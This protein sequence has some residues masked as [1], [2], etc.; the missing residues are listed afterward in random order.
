MII[1]NS[2]RKL[3]A[4]GVL[5]L[6]VSTLI[7]LPLYS[8]QSI[9]RCGTT[10]YM[11]NLKANDPKLEQKLIESEQIIQQWIRDN[12]DWKSRRAGTEFVIPVVVH[13]VY[14]TTAQN[15]TDQQVFSQIDVLNEDFARLNPDTNL[16][17]APFAA[18]A[19]S[20]PFRFCLAQRDPA[21]QSTN[22]I[23]RRQTTSTSFSSTSNNIKRY[24]NG[25]LDAWDVTRYLNI[26]VGNLSGGTLGYAESPTSTPSNT[27]GIAIDYDAFGRNGSASSPYH[28]GRTATHEIGHCFNL[29]HI[30]GD[31]NGAC[32]GSDQCN[33]TPNQAGS[34]SSCFTFPTF[35]SCTPAGDGIMFMNYM[36]Y[37]YDNCLNLFTEDQAA[38]MIAAVNSFYPTLLSSNGCLPVVSQIHDAGV[39]AINSPSGTFC[40][41]VIHPVVMI[42]NWGNDTLRILTIN[43]SLNNAPA[44]A[45]FWIGALAPL[46]STTL[47]LPAMAV[48]TGANQ[49]QVYSSLPNG[50]PDNNNVNDSSIV[51]FYVNGSLGNPLPIVQDFES[52]FPPA[53][54]SIDNPDGLN[55][56]L[57]S[58]LAAHSPLSSA[59]FDNFIYNA[60]GQ[61]DHLIIPT[62]NLQN[63]S[64]PVL[65][66]WLA[67]AHYSG[68]TGLLT[69][70]LSISIS[71]DC[72]SSWVELFREGGENLN[73]RAGALPVT[74][75][76][77]PVAA[78][79]KRM[80]VDLS[81]YSTASSA[82]LRF[83]NINGYGNGLFLDDINVDFT[84]GIRTTDSGRDIVLYPNPA[85]DYIQIKFNQKSTSAVILKL[86]T[87][88]GMLL[89]EE[90][91]Q[92]D[93]I[94][95]PLHY[96][97]GIY[98][99][100]LRYP[101]RIIHK[102]FMIREH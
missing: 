2:G 97:S 21:G 27:F 9:Q 40:D 94:I 23:Q 56:W 65:S 84:T 45:Q 19:A 49:L 58:I 89:K 25:G 63:G 41:S 80:T 26:W 90:V 31:D 16:T 34:T 10:E 55:T 85:V 98:F 78:D 88:D 59:Y 43:Y 74:S 77:I 66:Y 87:I 75:N 64:Q 91:F 73:T 79:W 62:V 20:T 38:R 15:L 60:T 95:L 47:N 46:D 51:N 30:W 3:C 24:A 96:A 8:Q 22:G 68:T 76:F 35:D 70:T 14:N 54:F 53:G 7:N 83:T 44:S 39:Q 17:P 102:S 99:L 57:Q 32:T 93:P 42:K 36:D 5:F 100:E 72:G 37:S 101:D 1:L 4:R 48:G 50:N 92:A 28:L 52:A 33:D 69:D 29:R 82:L 6:L 86:R 11:D 12:P 81:A 18:I 13:I 71:T 61:E 67:Y